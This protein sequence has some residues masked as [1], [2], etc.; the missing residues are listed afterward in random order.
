[1]S[2][3]PGPA[4]RFTVRT[5]RPT[6][7]PAMREL[8]DQLDELQRD[9]RV[10]RPRAGIR[11]EYL[12]EY[13][14]AMGRDGAAVFVAEEGGAGS[15]VVGMCY[16]HEVIPSGHSNDRAVELSSVVVAG[17]SRRLGIGRALVEAGARFAEARGIDRLTIRVFAANPALEFWEEIGFSPRFVQLTA[18]PS[19]VLDRL[20]RQ[21]DA[22]SADD[23]R[24]TQE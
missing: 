12:A 15:R 16:A 13:E 10:F 6:D 5:A 18:R 2:E 20:V 22:G 3:R 21:R 14:Q 17:T 19:D 23:S 1:M 9:W 24:P 4:G 11:E 8:F 7:L